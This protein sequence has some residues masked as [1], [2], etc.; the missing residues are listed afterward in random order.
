ML[1][2]G[3]E[4]NAINPAYAAKLGLRVCPTNV[5]AQ[6]IDRSTFSTHDMVLANYQ[7]E[8]KQDRLRFF[9]EAFLVANTAIEVVLGMFFLSLSKIEIN[10]AEGEL[11]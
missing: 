2:L 3:S 11:S 4:V 8:D 10:F 7:L 5:G 6:K 9:Q 1:D